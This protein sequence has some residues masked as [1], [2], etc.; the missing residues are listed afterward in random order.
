ML[1]VYNVTFKKSTK[2]LYSKFAVFAVILSVIIRTTLIIEFAWLLISLL[3]MKKEQT[4]SPR[5]WTLP[6]SFSWIIA[7]ISH[8]MI[9]KKSAFNDQ[10]S[11][12]CKFVK[13]SCLEEE[14]YFSFTI[15][16]SKSL[17]TVRRSRL[18]TSSTGMMRCEIVH[19][20]NAAVYVISP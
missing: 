9:F 13:I 2:K 18:H 6:Y 8:Q 12:V 4:I 19:A 1:L 10:E 11:P 5:A 15:T 3:K 17:K 16:K 20:V 14:R 7:S